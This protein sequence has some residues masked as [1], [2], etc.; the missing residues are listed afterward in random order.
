MV[1]YF[2]KKFFLIFQKST[3]KKFLYLLIFWGMEFSSSNIKKKKIIFYQKKA[4][5]I[6]PEME[7]PHFSGSNFSS[8]K[9]KKQK[10]NKKQKTLC[11]KLLKKHVI[12]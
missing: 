5:L 10:Q 6:F 12:F 1:L 3:L 11:K 4:F 7:I 2:R 8:T 9:N